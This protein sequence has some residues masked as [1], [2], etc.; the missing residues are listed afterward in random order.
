VI[1]WSSVGK[2]SEIWFVFFRKYLTALLVA[3]ALSTVAACGL[4]QHHETGNGLPP[5]ET[6]LS[7]AAADM[8]GA[9]ASARQVCGV[10]GQKAILTG[11]SNA[12][13]GTKLA[14]FKCQ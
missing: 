4:L 12:A 6:E 1:A 9:N 10:Y 2:S 14:N 11:T 13:D 8:S 3:A 7:Y 5:Q